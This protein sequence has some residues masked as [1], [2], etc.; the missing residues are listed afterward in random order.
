MKTQFFFLLSLLTMAPFIGFSQK[1]ES[2]YFN[3]YTD[4]LKKGQHNYINVDGKL[5][6]G[7]WLPLTEKEIRF[8]CEEAEFEGNEL[9]IPENFKPKK[10]NIIATL[11]DDPSISVQRTIWVKQQPDPILPTRE[12]LE[13]S[14]V[15]RKNKR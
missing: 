10:V 6:N 14:P 2:I 7:K 9:I 8:S 13:G 4:S 11:K 12:E 5:K 15:K 1:V 3:L